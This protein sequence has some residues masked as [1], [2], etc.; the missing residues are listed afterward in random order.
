M[1]NPPFRHLHFEALTTGDATWDHLIAR[2]PYHHLTELL[3]AFKANMNRTANL[4]AA[5]AMIAFLAKTEHLFLMNAAIGAHGDWPRKVEHLDQHPSHET[6][7]IML[8]LAKEYEDQPGNKRKAEIKTGNAFIKRCQEVNKGLH[9]SLESILALV[10]MESWTALEYLA[11]DL[12]GAAVDHGPPHL[13]AKILAKTREKEKATVKELFERNAEPQMTLGGFARESQ[14]FTFQKM[15][16]ISDHYEWVNKK[17]KA[18]FGAA[19]YVFALAATRNLLTHKAGIVDKTF[20]ANVKDI[21]EL[22]C[23][24][25]GKPVMLDGRIV[26]K[27]RDAT[28][29]LGLK[30]IEAIDAIIRTGD[31][32]P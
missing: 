9:S 1:Q 11:G 21:P 29:K 3:A 2:V 18:I 28:V 5:P 22:S 32:D 14:I 10:V 17:F 27:M 8:V 19:D 15:R 7:A 13:R 16:T 25:L 26:S 30:L 24:H 23:S 4:V 12:W 20:H 6:K 31:F